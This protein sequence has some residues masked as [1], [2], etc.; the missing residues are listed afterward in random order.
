MELARP[1]P[2]LGV[3]KLGGAAR[4]TCSKELVDIGGEGCCGWFL[5]LGS[6]GARSSDADDADDKAYL[7]GLV[8]RGLW[9]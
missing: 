4:A 9:C 7:P 5:L 8:L 1:Y 3:G 2:V 6:G